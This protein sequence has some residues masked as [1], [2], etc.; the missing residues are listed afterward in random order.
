MSAPPRPRKQRNGSSARPT[1][2]DERIL[3]AATAEFAEWGYA[4]ARI[5]RISKR[6]GTNDRSLYYYFSSKDEL[7]GAVLDRAYRDLAEAEV[8]LDIKALT[9]T[10]G[11]EAIVSFI[12][13]YYETHPEFLSL[14]NS[15]NLCEGVHLRRS[16]VATHISR[17]QLDIIEDLLARG[18]KTGEFRKGVD[19]LHVFLTIAALSY[20]YQS[21]RF[22]LAEYLGVDLMK[23]GF[24]DGWVQHMK[25]VVIQSIRR[26]A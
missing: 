2:T 14:V 12:W 16:K 13:D 1:T 11:I 15:E 18:M 10:R 17:T 25:H 9:P 6:A 5:D 19:P 21:N 23:P 4:G 3:Q 24:R 7:F 22:T 20:F 8:R 26:T